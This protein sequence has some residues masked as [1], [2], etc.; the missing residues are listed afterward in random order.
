MLIM[1]LVYSIY[2]LVTN[3]I[4]S[5]RYNSDDLAENFRSN[6]DVVS[7]ALGSKLLDD[8]NAV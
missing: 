4:A 5:G 6:I 8:N 1:T 7:L 2:A 3:I